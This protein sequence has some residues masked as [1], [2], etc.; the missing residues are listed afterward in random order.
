[1]LRNTNSAPPGGLPP[2]VER[3]LPE[4][5][6]KEDP[7]LTNKDLLHETRRYICGFYPYMDWIQG[8]N[9]EKP[10]CKD[11]A[12]ALIAFLRKRGGKANLVVGDYQRNNL[13][14]KEIVGH[15]WVHLHLSDG[16]VWAIDPTFQAM[17]PWNPEQGHPFVRK[18]YKGLYLW[19]TEVASN[20]W[21]TTTTYRTNDY[22]AAR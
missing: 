5:T 16:R 21:G 3:Y 13:L 14:G 18:A 20:G 1:M 12:A 4:L 11:R 19:E 10:D 8:R 7:T 15:A 17:Q 2:I 22:I 6:Q 9:G